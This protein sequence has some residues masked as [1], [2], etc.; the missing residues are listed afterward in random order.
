VLFALAILRRNNTQL[1][2]RE[3]GQAAEILCREA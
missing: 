3:A 2:L 1:T